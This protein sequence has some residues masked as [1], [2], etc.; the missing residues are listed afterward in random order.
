[1]SY[2]GGDLGSFNGRSPIH[3]LSG[4]SLST[5]F[6]WPKFGFSS[7]AKQSGL[8]YLPICADLLWCLLLLTT[9]SA[10]Q[11]STNAS[12]YLDHSCPLGFTGSAVLMFDY[13]KR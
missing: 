8:S 12:S 13:G 4:T 11:N 9:G 3:H 5:V 6:P 1:M 2:V 10:S 7:R